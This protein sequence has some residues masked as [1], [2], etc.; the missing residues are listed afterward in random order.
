MLKTLKYHAFSKK[1]QFF[2]LFAVIVAVKMKIYL[3][4]E[5]LD[6]INNMK[7]CRKTGSRKRRPRIQIEKNRQN[8]KLFYSRNKA[9]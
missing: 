6:L 3:K 4:K 5:I 7:R 1:H 8:K 9:K 2:Y